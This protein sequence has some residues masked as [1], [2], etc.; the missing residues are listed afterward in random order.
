MPGEPACVARGDVRV[1][2]PNPASKVGPE[3]KPL[4]NALEESKVNA[5]ESLLLVEAYNSR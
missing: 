2:H 3:I 1:N 5:V 4:E